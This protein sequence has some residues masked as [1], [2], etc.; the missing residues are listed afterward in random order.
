MIEDVAPLALGRSFACPSSLQAELEAATRIRALQCGEPGPFRQCIAALDQAAW[1]LCARRAGLP[2]ARLF[3]PRASCTVPTYASGI[4]VADA[5]RLAPELA[6]LGF[7]RLKLKVGFDAVARS[8]RGRAGAGGAGGR[9][10]ADV[11][12]QPG[13]VA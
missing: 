4:H 8:C 6:A 3:E 5:E 11:R 12:R 7:M 2:V 10:E 13:L 1:D 9:A